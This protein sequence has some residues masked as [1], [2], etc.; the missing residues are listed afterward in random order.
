MTD[1]SLPA[2]SRIDANN[3]SSPPN[4]S[5]WY[6]R[7]LALA[8]ELGKTLLDRNRVLDQALEHAR[9]EGQQKDIELQLLHKQ[10]SELRALSQKRGALVDEA[11]GYNQELDRL[12]RQ[13]IKELTADR[14]KI[15]RLKAHVACLEQEVSDL[16]E[17]LDHCTC[18]HTY[19]LRPR[20]ATNTTD[21]CAL[22]S[23][24][25]SPACYTPPPNHST[26]SVTTHRH[27]V[28]TKGMFIDDEFQDQPQLSTCELHSTSVIQTDSSHHIPGVRWPLGQMCSSPS[29]C[30][31][32]QLIRSSSWPALY[33][34]NSPSDDI[35][36]ALRKPS[37]PIQNGK[38][39]STVF[40]YADDD[41]LRPPPRFGSGSSTH[42]TQPNERSSC[43]ADDLKALK[44]VIDDA[45]FIRH[46][47]AIYCIK[48]R[49]Q[50]SNDYQPPYKQLFQEAFQMLRT[51]KTGHAN[52]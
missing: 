1:E 40:Q 45:T 2:H 12:N 24:P 14:Q 43:T 10:L 41:G 16:S 31:T 49:C 8:A 30:P 7:D 15:E 32:A 38:W 11:D 20:S 5:D 46:L 33:V 29:F 13:L 44:D 26:H 9:A 21:R 22:R 47:E 3:P 28:T 50:V 27:T 35:Q 36:P 19:P 48:L 25:P 6:V 42:S 4:H 34:P 23:G 51:L 18:E 39:T 37:H 17:L 52:S